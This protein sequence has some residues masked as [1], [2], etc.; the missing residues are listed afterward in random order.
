MKKFAIIHS[1]REVL[2]WI[3]DIESST[4]AWPISPDCS[5]S[6]VQ[7]SILRYRCVFTEANDFEELKGMYMEY[8]L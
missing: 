1:P 5:V 4:L 8:F 2:K 7:G 6:D 3:L